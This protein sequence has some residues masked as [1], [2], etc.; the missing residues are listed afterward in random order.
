MIHSTQ[1]SGLTRHTA[2]Q[3]MDSLTRHVVLLD[4][5][6]RVV[7]ANRA[8]QTAAG[9]PEPGTSYLELCA[10][11]TAELPPG[12]DRLRGGLL[13]VMEGP[14]PAFELYAEACVGGGEPH[15]FRNRITRLEDPDGRYFLVS[16]EDLGVL[17]TLT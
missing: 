9:A 11:P 17:G 16:H 13:A 6:G 3:V 14:E 5:A 4:E 12:R 10:S 1:P 2:R 15:L 7:A 8:L